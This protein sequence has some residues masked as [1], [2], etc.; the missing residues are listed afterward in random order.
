V[1]QVV[2]TGAARA[3]AGVDHDHELHEHVVDR[4]CRGWAR[5][6]N[7]EDVAAAD[8]LLQLHVDLPIRKA[9]DAD[10]TE[11]QAEVRGDLLRE[12]LWPHWAMIRACYAGVR[13]EN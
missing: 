10:V 5:R 8:G 4:R 1:S 12:T 3:P 13:C 9:L 2:A 11:L 7:E 6:L